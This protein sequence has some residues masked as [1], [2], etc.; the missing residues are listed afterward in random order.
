MTMP[1]PPRCAAVAQL[2][3]LAAL[4]FVP[5]A[6]RSGLLRSHGQVPFRRLEQGELVDPARL[7]PA[8]SLP[9]VTAA[10]GAAYLR[11]K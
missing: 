2:V 1:D 10:S 6:V 4:F 7:L 8:V 5:L 3:A 9:M 11:D